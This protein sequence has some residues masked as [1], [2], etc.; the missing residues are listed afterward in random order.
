MM[1]IGQHIE[2]LRLELKNACDADERRQ[3]GGELELAQAD[4]V[5]TLA[6]QDG[7]INAE[8][9]L[10]RRL[11]C[12]WTGSRCAGSGFPAVRDFIPRHSRRQTDTV[13]VLDPSLQQSGRSPLATKEITINCNSPCQRAVISHRGYC[14]PRVRL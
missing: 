13:A 3:I 14:S 6:E 10:L 7:A 4:L 1:T 8:P 12:S 2:K 5:V 11:F 9:P